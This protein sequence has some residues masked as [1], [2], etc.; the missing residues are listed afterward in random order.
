MFMSGLG[1]KRDARLRAWG[2][3]DGSSESAILLSIARAPGDR[4]AAPFR[5]VRLA[6]ARW[7]G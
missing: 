2:A 5:S 6:K 7:T 1:Q 3:I 4:S